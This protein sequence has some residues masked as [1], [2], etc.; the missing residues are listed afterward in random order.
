MIRKHFSE[1]GRWGSYTW[2]THCRE[3]EAGHNVLL[4]G[5]MG[6][7]KRSPTISTRLQWIAE[8]SARYPNKIVTSLAHL[9]DVDLL[10]AAYCLTRKDGAVGVDG[11]CDGARVCRE[12]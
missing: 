8:Q 10:R 6:D 7:T 1:S 9:I 4:G 12:P 3:G 2:A 11:W 5:T